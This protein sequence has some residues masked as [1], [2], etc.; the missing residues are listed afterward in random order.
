MF[1]KMFTMI[2]ELDSLERVQMAEL[3]DSP[4]YRQ[5]LQVRFPFTGSF[6]K[7][8]VQRNL[9][10][11]ESRLKKSALLSHYTANSSFFKLKGHHCE[12]CIKPIS[13]S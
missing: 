5:F 9:R 8:I 13:A 12:K 4:E 11:V 10:W 6:F 2:Q 1:V 3:G 7:G